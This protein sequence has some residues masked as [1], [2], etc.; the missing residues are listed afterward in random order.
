MVVRFDIQA[1]AGITAFFILFIACSNWFETPQVG[2]RSFVDGHAVMIINLEGADDVKLQLWDN[3]V[4]SSL[5]NLN[6]AC[7]VDT[8]NLKMSPKYSHKGDKVFLT[9]V[10]E[11]M[12]KYCLHVPSHLSF[13]DFVSIA[14]AFYK[15]KGLQVTFHK[16]YKISLSS[17]NNA[18]IGFEGQAITFEEYQKYGNLSTDQFDSL[19]EQESDPTL[20]KRLKDLKTMS[21]EFDWHLRV[22]TVG[23]LPEENELPHDAKPLSWHFSAWELAP[24]KGEGV[25]VAV[26]DTGSASFN[27]PKY[28]LKHHPNVK[29]ATSVTDLALNLVAEN[30][31]S[32]LHQLAILIKKYCP[33]IK[34]ND[35]EQSLQGMVISFLESEN[36]QLFID[37]LLKYCPD[38]KQN[39]GALNANGKAA[40]EE[41]L[42][43]DEGV[44]PGHKK[45]FFTLTKLNEKP[46]I[47]ELLPSPI[48]KK[49]MDFMAT[50]GTFT[51]GIINAQPQFKGDITGIAPHVTLFPIKALEDDGSTTKQNL[52]HALRLA[53][54]LNPDI[55]NLSLKSGESFSESDPDDTSM[56]DL[57][58]L[59]PYVVSASGNN[60]NPR[61][62][63][64][65]GS[66]AYPAK[67]DTVEFSVA[68]FKF[69]NFSYP[70]GDFSQ[71]ERNVGPQF[72]APGFNMLS[73]AINPET[74]EM[75]KIFMG[76]TSAAVPVITGCVAL[77]LGEFK[78]T[79]SR[80]TILKVLYG[81]TIKMNGSLKWKNEIGLGMIDIRTALL[82]LHTLKEIKNQGIDLGLE[83][84][85]LISHIFSLIFNN[86][87]AA[88]SKMGIVS[89]RS[90]LALF[91]K[92]CTSG[93]FDA[94]DSEKIITVE[95]G[96]TVKDVAQLIITALTKNKKPLPT[97]T[98]DQEY[99]SGLTGNEEIASRLQI[100][101]TTN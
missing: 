60:G 23:V 93:N 48:A 95:R 64:Y 14:T 58:G 34:V 19:I 81:S 89:V 2:E 97:P 86:S 26:I 78:D 100:A 42:Y 10:H 44:L 75:C 94:A 61:S 40:L 41:I 99:F 67:F 53:S 43:G 17:L 84:N 39:N 82:C 77:A 3:L 36:P 51:Q 50:H 54:S 38:L 8:A 71:V 65:A 11:E 72:A 30:G 56:R 1:I 25:S 32:P 74:G 16:D 46:V 55:V 85:D 9:H 98:S 47:V 20:K 4:H 57:V 15:E 66:L 69:E 90:D 87:D 91:C 52:D 27:L 45:G 59:F 92:K 76:G 5:H 79:F 35:I 37:F 24:G 83:E 6:I 80:E 68:G 101:V 63:S 21:P 18:I 70:L 33:N 88:S 96:A 31:L 28:G 73:S 12:G 49:E 22:P 7:A 13:Q 29:D 62:S